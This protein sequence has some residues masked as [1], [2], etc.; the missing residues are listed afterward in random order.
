MMMPAWLVCLAWPVLSAM[1]ACATDGPGRDGSGALA[2]ADRFLAVVSFLTSG[3][4]LAGACVA[5]IALFLV[6]VLLFRLRLLRMELRKGEVRGAHVQNLRQAIEQSGGAQGVEDGVVGVLD[7]CRLSLG[8]S[9]L[10]VGIL[11]DHHSDDAERLFWSFA[12]GYE[13]GAIRQTL[14]HALATE[15]LRTLDGPC[16]LHDVAGYPALF[17][18]ITGLSQL[19]GAGCVVPYTT[20]GMRLR[21]CALFRRGHRPVPDAE[22]VSLQLDQA[23][24]VLSRV[25]WRMEAE[26]ALARERGLRSGMFETPGL[27][28]L[29]ANPADG[30]ILDANTAAAE[31]FGLDRKKL[32]AMSLWQLHESDTVGAR[33]LY[34]HAAERGQTFDM[35]YGSRDSGLRD[36][37]VSVFSLQVDGAPAVFAI[38]QDVTARKRVEAELAG[39]ELRLRNLVERSPVPLALCDQQCRFVYANPAYAALFGYARSEMEGQHFSM[40][41]PEGGLEEFQQFHDRFIQEAEISGREWTLVRKDGEHRVMEVS[42]FMLKG[43]GGLPQVATYMQD[44][45]DRQRLAD[46]MIQS[47]K[48]ASV[49]GLAAGMAH[50]INNPLGGILQGCQNIGRR[51]DPSLVANRNI[52]DS[53]NVSMEDVLR[54]LEERSILRFLDGIRESAGRAARITANMLDFS[55]RGNAQYAPVLLSELMDKALELAEN[56]Y[57]LKKRF[58]FRQISIVREYQP[59]MEPVPCVATEVEQVALNLLKNAAQAMGEASPPIATPVIVVRTRSESGQAIFEVEDSGPGMSKGVAR[60]IFEPFYTTKKAGSGTGLGLAVSYFI[61][62]NNHRGTIQVDSVPGRGSRFTVALPYQRED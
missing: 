48:M 5:L 56:D 42:C 19:F 36:L 45:T 7:R 24:F 2:A 9:L 1:P 11:P 3:A 21:I 43:T 57:D 33:G 34:R 15:Y 61:I 51:L 8:C 55:R 40:L 30:T 28:K 22:L 10:V 27:A 29:L 62:T 41:L 31:L 35:R 23:C 59:G 54:Y 25:A 14:E 26:R 4:F 44:I 32:C 52:A 13:E 18:P 38:Y 6:S 20:A 12:E 50:E 37:E 60:R 16:W 47:E 46:M 58:D 49:G 17:A 53:L 39:S